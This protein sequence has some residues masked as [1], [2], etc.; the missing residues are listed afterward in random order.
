[1]KRI[2]SIMMLCALS[3]ALLLHCAIGPRRV[4]PSKRIN[5]K[6]GTEVPFS[7]VMTPGFAQDYVRADIITK[8][9]F[10]ASGM[11]AWTMKIP[12]GYMVFQAVP[13]SGQGKSNPL[14]GQSQGEFVLIPRSKGELVFELNPGDPIILRGGTEVI[15]GMGLHQVKFIASSIQ[16]TQ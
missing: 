4:G 8:A 15:K 3:A 14:S 12:K 9:D 11:G 7:K 10:F 2:K 13:P 1:M 6:P 5:I 16:K